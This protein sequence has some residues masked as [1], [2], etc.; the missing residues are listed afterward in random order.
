VTVTTLLLLVICHPVARID[1]AYLCSTKFD[2]FGF[3]RSND[4]TGAQKFLMFHMTSLRPYQGQ[5]V[6][7]ML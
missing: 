3:S 6:V 1:I 2:D 7:R 4:M 5:F